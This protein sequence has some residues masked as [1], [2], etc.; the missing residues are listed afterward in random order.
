MYKRL[1]L[2]RTLLKPEGVIFI[3]I[4]DN[5]QAQLKLLCDRVFSEENFVGA[6]VWKNA[7]D[8]NPTNIATEHQYVYCYSKNRV[9]LSPVWKSPHSHYKEVLL[10]KEKELLN[11]ISNQELLQKAYT[12]WFRD[13]KQFLGELDRYKYIDADGV[14]TGSQSVHNPGKEGYRYDVL[15]PVTNKP[16][17]QPLMGYRFPETTMKK[18]LMDGKILF[19]ENESKIIELKVYAKDYQSKFSSLIELDGRIGANELRTIFWD[20]DKVFTNP[21][22]STF[23]AE[24]LG[25]TAHK[26]A[27]ILDFFAGSGTTLHAVMAL[28]AEDGGNRQC[29]LVTN[30]ENNIAEEVCYERNRR[31]IKAIPTA[32]GSRCRASLTIT[33]SITRPPTLVE[34]A[35]YPINAS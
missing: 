14:Y 32:R 7:T 33:C 11:E 18:L 10:E 9:K 24:V 15:H 30:N 20:S 28:N 1:E 4:D 27:L 26:N 2:A 22:P 8:N 34:S 17:K 23:I 21:K 3:S 13:N 35:P 29:I 5:E 12:K 16:C 19:G 25:F 31:V 6:I